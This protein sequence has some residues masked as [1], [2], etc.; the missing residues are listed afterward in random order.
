MPGITVGVDG[1]AHSQQALE[2]AMQEAA[3]R[4]TMLTVLSVHE[5]AANHWTGNPMIVPA[6]RADEE[7]DRRAAEDLVA[8]VSGQLGESRPS[9]VNVVAVSGLAAQEL[10]NASQ[11]SDLVVVGSRGVGGFASLV[12]GS[13]TA[14]VVQHAA[15][16]VTVVH[17]AQ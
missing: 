5:V 6:D 14:K 7:K 4:N 12:L 3:I 15:C 10:I 2:W 1:S 16:P 8:K 17:H 13:V 9:S 11:D